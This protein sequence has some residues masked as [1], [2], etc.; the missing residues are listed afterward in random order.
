[1]TDSN[2]MALSAI[3]AVALLLVVWLAYRRP[4]P[5]R[6]RLPFTKRKGLLTAAELRFYR[7]LREA[8]PSGPTVFVKVRLMDVVAVPDGAWREFGAPGSGLHLDFVL[9]DAQSTE[10]LLVVELDDRSH[11]QPKARQH[12][13]FKDAALSAAGV[14]LLRVTAAARYDAGE[15]R[16]R[17]AETLNGA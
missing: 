7:T 6:P 14:P 12:D 11:A 5:V 9:A 13:Q 10:A 2:L 8:V 16:L 4:S 3:C 15:I 17:I 1:M